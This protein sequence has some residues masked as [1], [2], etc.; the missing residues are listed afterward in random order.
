MIF[1][2]EMMNMLIK[3]LDDCMF[4][5]VPNQGILYIIKKNTKSHGI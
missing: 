1:I 2:C 4:H 3:W 5:F